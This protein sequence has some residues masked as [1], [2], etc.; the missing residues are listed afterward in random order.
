MLAWRVNGVN[1]WEEAPAEPGEQNG[2]IRHEAWEALRETNDDIEIVELLSWVT[3]D[4]DTLLRERRRL[5]L[6][7]E[8]AGTAICCR[9]TS[10]FTVAACDATISGYTPYS[11]ISYYGLGFRF[12]RALD[13]G[14]QHLD[15]EGRTGEEG[16][17]GQPARW[18]YYHG[19]L[20]ETATAVGVL[21]ADS[22]QNPRH[23]TPWFQVSHPP[24]PFAYVTAS[25][26][27]REPY[28]LKAGET[29]K[30]DYAVWVHE[31]AW[32]QQECEAQWR[33]QF[34]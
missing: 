6:S 29:L 27:A 4:G 3:V 31:G 17:N 32:S 1:F 15:A 7:L 11:P 13:I 8:A 24:A 9:W 16:D 30:L 21:M 10:E 28:E 12:A 23:P 34:A 22:P 5:F 18:H 2:V 19:R 26:V 33:A 14:G 25:L 20:D